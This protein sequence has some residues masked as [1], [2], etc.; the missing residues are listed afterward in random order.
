M[1]M[2]QA[3]LHPVEV[4]TP[5]G[6]GLFDRLL[7]LAGWVLLVKP[8]DAHKLFDPSTIRPLL[9]QEPQEAM[10]GRWPVGTPLSQRTG[11]LQRARAL[12]EQEQVMQRIEDILLPPIDAGV[13]SE[14]LPLAKDL[15]MERKG[16][17]D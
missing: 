7:H 2:L 4:R 11:I 5:V 3:V 8:Q 10:V 12:F 17:E 1:R 14:H 13:T 9:A 16:F 15:Y 6:E